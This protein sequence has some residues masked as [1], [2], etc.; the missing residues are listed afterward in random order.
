MLLKQTRTLLGALVLTNFNAAAANTYAIDTDKRQVE[1][2]IQGLYAKPIHNLEYFV[3]KTPV[4]IGSACTYLKRTFDDSLLK[5]SHGGCSVDVD[6]YF[7]FPN[8]SDIDMSDLD[9]ENTLPKHKI[10]SIS[11]VGEKAT[12]KVAAPIGKGLIPTRIVYL[13][14]KFENRWRISNI[15]AYFRW[16]LDL[17]GEFRN[18]SG[19]VGPTYE[20]ARK[21]RGPYEIEDLP[22]PCRFNMLDYYTRNGWP[23]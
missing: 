10:I 3:G 16:P 17:S 14:N 13:L 15:L 9:D 23:K 11:I 4:E 2:L 22:A 1:R 20:F 7:R 8:L 18:C 6:F 19:L 12:A 5:S 21:P